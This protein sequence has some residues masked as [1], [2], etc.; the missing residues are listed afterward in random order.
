M[1]RVFLIFSLLFLS[2]IFL[3]CNYEEGPVMSLRTPKAR[4]V[5]KWEYH[6]VS[7]NGM[8]ITSMYSN[9][10][11][12]IK[13]NGDATFCIRPDSIN[14]GSWKLSDDM[15]TLE[16]DMIDQAG[17]ETWWEDFTILKLKEKEMWLTGEV[18]GMTMKIEY[19]EF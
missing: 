11:A 19:R 6:K 9:G 10:Y 18:N 13:K 16:V 3:S 4:V 1:I 5:N 17:V 8:D 7:L 14:F 12:D 15:K 2:L